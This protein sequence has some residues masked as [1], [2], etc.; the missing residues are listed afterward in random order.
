MVLCPDFGS[1]V[2]G[3]IKMIDINI[4]EDLAYFLRE[5]LDFIR[6]T[7]GIDLSRADDLSKRVLEG[8]ARFLRAKI[9]EY[10]PARSK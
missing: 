8:Q 1:K 4:D 2:N 9:E 7:N 3:P 6:N 10:Y 5:Y